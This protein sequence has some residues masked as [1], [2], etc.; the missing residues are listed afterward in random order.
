MVLTNSV[1][2]LKLKGVRRLDAFSITNNQLL[3]YF[4]LHTLNPIPYDQSI[5]ANLKL[6]SWVFPLDIN[7]FQMF[8]FRAIKSVFHIVS[9]IPVY[10]RFLS[11]A[12]NY[13]FKF[14]QWYKL[15]ERNRGKL[16][17]RIG[18]RK[19]EG[20]EQGRFKPLFSCKDW[21]G[22]FGN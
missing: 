5:L 6:S 1:I 13:I 2:L 16:N 11:K 19:C 17:P 21:F 10:L 12:S 18:W 20:G 7:C 9:F 22:A 3:F 15:W 14:V 4:E 8:V